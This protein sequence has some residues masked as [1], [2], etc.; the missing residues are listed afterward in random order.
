MIPAS[1][2]APLRSAPDTQPDTKPDIQIVPFEADHIA[3][4]L[5][6]SQAANWPH[7]AEDWALMLSVSRG[8]VAMQGEQVVGTALCSVMGD[9]AAISLIIVDATCRGQ[10]LGRVLMERVIAEGGARELR[11]TATADGL[12]LYEK[13]GFVAQGQV[14]Q[15][16]GTARAMTPEQDV[17]TGTATDLAAASDADLD[18][19]GMSRA[20]LLEYIAQDGKILTTKGGFG[21]LRAFGRGYVVGPV[22]ARTPEAA[23][24][25]IAA[26][27]T[28]H[29]GQ[30][31]RV[32][33]PQE[34]ELGPFAESLG[35]THAGGGVKMT[36]NGQPHI[37]THYQTYALA[38]QALG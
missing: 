2:N 3:G 16:Q 19:T 21:F 13:L 4:A 22:V 26:A 5:R 24:A 14:V 6:L 34:R 30:F 32:D 18:A 1:H 31:L 28:S 12:P 27:A 36:R 17:R 25:L 7:R 35:L 23:R 11:L 37:T 29:A 33:F 15:Y 10:G 20:E 8:Y 9:V 38:S